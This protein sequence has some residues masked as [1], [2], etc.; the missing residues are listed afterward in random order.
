MPER[1]SQ[2]AP[3]LVRLNLDV[4]FVRGAAALSA[5]K[6]ATSRIPIVAVDLESDPVAMGFVRTLAQPGGNITGVF[7]DLPELSAKQLQLLTEVIRP[8]ARVP[9]SAIRCS[10]PHNFGR[11]TSPRGR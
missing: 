11:R 2:L 4:L 9:S 6:H 5:A 10:T 8:I 7:L 3:D 1:L